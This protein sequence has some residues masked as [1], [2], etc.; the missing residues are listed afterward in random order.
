ML[1]VQRLAKPGSP[2]NS[3]VIT[4]PEGRRIVVRLVRSENGHARIGVEAD[5]DVAILRGEIVGRPVTG[6]KS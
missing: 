1:V 4:T 6:R 5:P 2:Q 3:L